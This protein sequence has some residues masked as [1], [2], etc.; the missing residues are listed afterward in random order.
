M[1][2]QAKFLGCL[3]GAIGV[4]YPFD[5]QVEASDPIAAMLALYETHEH[6][7]R[8]ELDPPSLWRLYDPAYGLFWSN[9]DGWVGRDS[10]ATEWPA[11]HSPTAINHLT[12]HPIWV[13]ADELAEL[14]HGLDCWCSDCE[15]ADVDPTG[16]IVE[17]DGYA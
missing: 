9:A 16:G 5:V 14:A 11:P 3:K 15:S 12:I 10:G 4:S 2:Y 7:H 13:K 1:M 17:R 6:I 8:L